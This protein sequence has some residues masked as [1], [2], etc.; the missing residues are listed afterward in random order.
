[1]MGSWLEQEE[2]AVPEIKS[3]Q[4]KDDFKEKTERILGYLLRLLDNKI[5]EVLL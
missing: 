1:M 3:V 5:V 2:E 4:Y